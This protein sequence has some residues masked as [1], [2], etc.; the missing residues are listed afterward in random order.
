MKKTLLTLIL[1]ATIVSISYAQFTDGT[2]LQ[3]THVVGRQINAAGEVTRS[4]ESDFSYNDEGKVVAFEIPQYSLSSVYLYVDDYLR[5]EGV[6]HAGGDPN[7][8]GNPEILEFLEYSYNEEGK[9]KH[10]R[11]EWSEMNSTEDWEYSYD[12][13]GR[14]KQKDYKDGE[15]VYHQHYIYDYEDEGKTVIESYWTSWEL[16]GLKLKKRTDF[17]YDEDYNLN[18]VYT[19]VYNLD[20]EITSTTMVTYVYTLSGKEASQ[21]KQTLTE[22]EWINTSVQRYIYDEQDRV[23]EQ[24]NGIWSTEDNDWDINRKITFSYE[25]Q[26]EDLVCTISFYK[27][28]GEEWV[29]DVFAN[30]TVLFGSQ[31]K[32]QQKTLRHF[33]YEEMNGAGNINQFEFTFSYTLEPIYLDFEEQENMVS[34]VYPNPTMGLVTV[35]GKSL[36][37]V[38]VANVMGQHLLTATSEGDELTINISNLPAGIYFVNITDGEGRKC[39]RKLVKE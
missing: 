37:Q 27:K 26:E 2:I 35:T 20:G 22:G 12:E 29:W 3:P 14:L 10:L 38:E 32:T 25:P 30:Q 34:K 23:T 28:N 16:E 31:L 9:I 6:S 18:T 1:C 17:H 19:E 7:F 24:Q 5:Q 21:T 11:H 33:V 36:R 15:T 13:Y 8:G 4:F 39:V